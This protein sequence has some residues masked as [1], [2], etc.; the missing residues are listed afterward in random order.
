MKALYFVLGSFLLLFMSCKEKIEVPLKENVNQL[1]I[2]GEV[3]DQ[4]GPYFVKISRSNSFSS[5]TSFVPHTPQYVI[6]SDNEG[7]IDSL[8][9]YADGIYKT[10]SLQGKVGNTYY[11]TVKD[12]DKTYT[13][14]SK[15]NACPEI[16]SFYYYYFLSQEFIY[17][18]IVINEPI[19]ESNFYRYYVRK[20]NKSPEFQ[21][22]F[23]DRLINGSRW[24]FTPFRDEFKS[25][26]TGEFI[27]LGID[28]ANFNYWEILV[29]NLAKDKDGNQSAAPTNPPTNILGGEVLGY[30]S[31]HSK[32]TIRF[33]IP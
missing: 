3:S 18:S 32:K 5:S 8:V 6:I 7:N 31:A 9:K 26:D 24:R 15:L 10:S 28:K 21:Y 4:P 29:Q 22:V 13:A 16:D 14:Q 27:F 2:E 20:N 23:E 12:N 11:L 17:P 1:V 19:N 33:T 25:G 30:F